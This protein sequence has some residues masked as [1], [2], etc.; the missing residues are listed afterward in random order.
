MENPLP[1]NTPCTIVVFAGTS[2]GKTTLVSKILENASW[3]F[4]N[5]VKSIY[6]FGYH[7]QKAYDEMESKLENIRF[8]Y[9][10]PTEAILE[11][12]FN[13]TTH[14]LVVIDDYGAQCANNEFVESLFLR[15]SHH[16]NLTVL[17]ITQSLYFPGA[18][19][20]SQSLNTQYTILMKNPMGASQVQTFARQR[21]PGH[22][23]EFI[24]TYTKETSQPY[25]YLLVDSHPASDS[26][27]A[28]R[29]GILP[30]EQISVFSFS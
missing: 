16:L 23:K 10:M 6:Y 26:Q 18:K 11:P 14:D 20:R 24:S 15:G 1:F 27:Y 3:C 28:V 22:S 29:S 13:P 2:A 7:H 19:R 12:I 25:S 17:L 21:F 4:R 5:P 9:S 8:F 30:N